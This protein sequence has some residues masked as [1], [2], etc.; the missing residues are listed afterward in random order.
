MGGYGDGF[1]KVQKHFLEVL[2]LAMNNE[3]ELAG[4]VVN[5]FTELYVLD[6]ESWDI[7]EKMKSRI[8]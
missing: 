5:A 6:K 7:V 1:S 4:I 3:K 2:R 8:Q